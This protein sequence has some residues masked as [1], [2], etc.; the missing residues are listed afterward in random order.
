M[1]L[2]F[3]VFLGSRRR[4]YG[5]NRRRGRK[6]EGEEGVL[7]RQRDRELPSTVQRKKLHLKN[8]GIYCVCR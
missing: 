3:L 6:G 8:Q 2:V 1:R 7:G 5:G 4:Q